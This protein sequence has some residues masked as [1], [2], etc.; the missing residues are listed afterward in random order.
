M[1]LSHLEIAYELSEPIAQDPYLII[2]HAIRR[3]DHRVCMCHSL[4]YGRLLADDESPCFDDIDLWSQLS[5]PCLLR[6]H[7]VLHETQSKQVH[8]VIDEPIGQSMREVIAKNNKRNEYVDEKIQWKV[9]SSLVDALAYLHSPVRVNTRVNRRMAHRYI[10]PDTIYILESGVAQLGPPPLLH[11]L[12]IRQLSDMP[13]SAHRYLAPEILMMR[14][15]GD[16]VDI[17]SLGCTMFEYGSNKPFIVDAQPA[18]VEKRCREFYG[19]VAV[20]NLSPVMIKL[21]TSLLEFREDLRI[22]AV[23]LRQH[24][25]IKDTLLDPDTLDYYGRNHDIARSCGHAT[26]SVAS[27]TSSNKTVS[28]TASV[29]STRAPES[30]SQ[31]PT[32]DTVSMTRKTLMLADGAVFGRNSAIAMSRDPVTLTV[33]TM[34]LGTQSSAPEN[35]QAANEQEQSAII[36]TNDT[37]QEMN[38]RKQWLSE[39]NY[40]I[41]PDLPILQY[42]PDI[43][44]RLVIDFLND[45]DVNT[46]TIED[47][48][49][50][51]TRLVPGYF[52]LSDDLKTHKYTSSDLV[53][54]SVIKNML[55]ERLRPYREQLLT[56]STITRPATFHYG[57]RFLPKLNRSNLGP[58]I[59]NPESRVFRKEPLSAELE[60][61]STQSFVAMTKG[62]DSLP[63]SASTLAAA[64][65]SNANPQNRNVSIGNHS[66]SAILHD[67]YL[68]EGPSDTL[69]LKRQYF[70]LFPDLLLP[71]LWAP[72]VTGLMRA[73]ATNDMNTLRHLVCDERQLRAVDNSG[74]TALMY[75]AANNSIDA[76]EMLMRFE[77]GFISNEGSTALM[78]ASQRGNNDIVKLLVHQEAQMQTNSGTTALMIATKYYRATTSYILLDLEAGIQDASGKTALMYA[79]LNGDE[80]IT[81]MLAPRESGIQNINGETAL[82]HAL[83]NGNNH[84]ARLLYFREAGRISS[85]KSTALM[86]CA[87]TNNLEIGRELVEREGRLQNSHGDT[88]LM[89]A[90]TAGNIDL[91]SFLYKIEGKM[92]NTGGL[93]AMMMAARKGYLDI[94]KVLSIAE[95]RIQDY[96][97]NTALM[98]AVQNNRTD[99][100]KYLSTIEGGMQRKTGETALI[101]AVLMNNT[102]SVKVLASLERTL[103]LADGRTPGDIARSVNNEEISLIIGI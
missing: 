35:E 8:I 61:Q 7:E 1:A 34:P 29:S 51:V 59:L 91:V 52:P 43:V 96:A 49:N 39:N 102:E 87:K 57:E 67:N 40:G 13:T 14:S 24:F 100:V 89:H 17:W 58:V 26:S 101:D 41:N 80:E 19:K 75:A 69:V 3:A 55:E 85:T 70:V 54:M 28:S 5:H 93:T 18:L 95:M 25:R 48:L 86:L 31:I 72:D 38:E 76:V 45:H 78:F 82:M 83:A 10:C 99:I 88:A 2:R 12:G 94:V 46:I 73:A 15:Y 74:R 23:D 37:E 103:A 22:S 64:A 4:S 36:N 30:R 27:D 47:I 62:K 60:N 65:Y 56:S 32:L 84:I 68:E 33:E 71:D 63:T 90:A 42:A 50:R 53:D 81:L 92:Q 6:I 79:A 11:L 66:V 9:L 98:Y 97:G 16:K 44:D 20:Y 77:V 21:L